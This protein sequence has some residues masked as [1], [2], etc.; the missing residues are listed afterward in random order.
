M[1]RH[2]GMKRPSTPA[3]KSVSARQGVA[4][5]PPPHTVAQP[6]LH[7]SM[8][9]SVSLTTLHGVT[10]SAAKKVPCR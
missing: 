10:L 8:A 1:C 5:A 3:S 7:A 9:T 2:C 6:A 4:P